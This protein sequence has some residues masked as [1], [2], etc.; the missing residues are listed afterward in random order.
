MLFAGFHET[1]FFIS[2]VMKI[3]LNSQCTPLS[4]DGT[5]DPYPDT[6]ITSLVHQT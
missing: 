1:L 3:V 6:L 2:K 5:M 4:Q